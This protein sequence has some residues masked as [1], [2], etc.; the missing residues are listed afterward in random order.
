MIQST[1]TRKV[2]CTLIHVTLLILHQRKK[3]IEVTANHNQPTD[4][5]QVTD[6]LMWEASHPPVFSMYISISLILQKYLQTLEA[7][8]EN[9]PGSV[10]L[11]SLCSF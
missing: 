4:E 8:F 10:F 7:N 11:D 2:D 5:A 6:S 9:C 1:A 3:A